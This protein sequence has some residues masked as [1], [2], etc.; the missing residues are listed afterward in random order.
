[1]AITDYLKLRGRTWYV[2]VQIPPDLWAAARGK[3]EYVKTLKTGDLNEANKLK[4][5]YVAA[6]KR[7]IAALGR[8][9]PNPLAE[10]YDK[11][12]AWRDAM[13]R[14]KGDVLFYE[15]GDSEQ[16][17]YATDEF[18]SQIG[19]E[20]REFLET[21]GERAATSFYKIAKGEGTPLRGLIDTWLTEQT[22]TIT[23]QTIAQHR[24]VLK[25][26]C[27]WA[28][29]GVLIEDV[30]R[31]KA[32]EFVSHLLT[33]NSGLSRKTAKRY[34]SSLSSLW[35]WLCARGVARDNPWL[36]HG[37]GKRGKRGETLTRR[38]WNDDALKKLLRGTYT[39]RYTTI[40]HDLTRLA[41]ATGA[42]LEELCA[43]KI[44]DIHNRKDG[45]WI[46]V[47]EGKTEAAVREVPVHDSAAHVLMRRHNNSHGFVFEGLEPGGPDNKRS[48]YVSKAFGRYTRTLGLGE[49]R[50]VFHAL[51][52]TFTEAMEA[53]E[54]PESTTKLIIG[55]ARQSLTYGHYSRGARVK[56]RKHINKLCY[57]SDVMRLI[58]AAP[59]D[60]GAKQLQRLKKQGASKARLKRGKA[61]M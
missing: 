53:A 17:Y 45:W 28:G 47:R 18:L 54:V 13:E 9:K 36:R 3:R 34:V 4:H 22:G 7:Q 50:Q 49:Q 12:L 23:G 38:Q 52:N 48:W 30:E 39:P 15:G 29:E 16:P 37:V 14:H 24:T 1:M 20:A 2:R 46:T 42:R 25:A 11:A 31:R 41:L 21:H 33:P 60:K 35:I 40:L 26:F 8:H 5:A 32:G 58:R 51:R 44:S 6:F 10:L 55:H 27:A 59:D 61:S 43:L 19:D 57:A 56:L